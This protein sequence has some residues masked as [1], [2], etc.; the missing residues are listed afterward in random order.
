MGRR[1]NGDMFLFSCNKR[2]AAR[3]FASSSVCYKKKETCP[4]FPAGPHFPFPFPARLANAGVIGQDR[5]R[6]NQQLTFTNKSCPAHEQRIR[7]RSSAS[8]SRW[9]AGYRR[10]LPAGIPAGGDAGAA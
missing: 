1:E 3:E 8:D 9:R 7:D 10:E 2:T 4:H 5:P 6:S